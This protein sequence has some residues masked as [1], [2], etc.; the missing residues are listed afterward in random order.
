VG[1]GEE[2]RSIVARISGPP[3]DL[4]LFGVSSVAED[5]LV[6]WGLHRPSREERYGEVERP[7]PGVDRRG[8]ATV[9]RPDLGKD[10]RRMRRG[11]EVRLHLLGLVS[12]VLP[13]LVQGHAPTDLLWRR[14]DLDRA[15]QPGDLLQD[16]ASDLR[17]WPL[18][19]EGDPGFPP[20]AVLDD[21]LVRMEVQSCDERTRTIGGRQ[22]S[23]LPAAG[24]EA[25]GGVLELR[26][27]RRERDRELPEDLR[28]RMQRVAG[29][30]PGLIG[31]RRPWC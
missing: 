3:A 29:R 14:V 24:A 2:R 19:R 21:G 11:G 1:K 6:G 28:V 31:E 22:R 12:R 18:R 17:H 8:A 5:E 7:P 27:R 15:G 26:L 4:D 16:L 23:G 10:Q 9:G 20:A 13:V 25:Q 30:T